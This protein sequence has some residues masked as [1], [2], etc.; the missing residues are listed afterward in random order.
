MEPVWAIGTGKTASSEDAEEMHSAIRDKLAHLY[1][2]TNS[3][4][5]KDFIWW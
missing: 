1:N 4:R 2:K 3:K 5:Y